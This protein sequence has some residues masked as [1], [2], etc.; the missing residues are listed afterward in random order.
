ME[1]ILENTVS[2][3]LSESKQFC[4]KLDVYHYIG[5]FVS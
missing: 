1:S 2:Y 5:C 4:K 3:V